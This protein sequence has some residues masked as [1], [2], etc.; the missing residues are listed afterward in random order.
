LGRN[1]HILKHV[2]LQGLSPHHC[3]ETWKT[4]M[5]SPKDLIN[6]QGWLASSSS[7][8]S[9]KH[10]IVNVICNRCDCLHLSWHGRVY[11]NIW[12]GHLWMIIMSLGMPMKFKL[13]IAACIGCLTMCLLSKYLL[14]P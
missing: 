11:F 9:S 13:K 3:C 7:I 10:L 5:E 14:P 6:I 8:I 12:K 1:L 2:P 4:C